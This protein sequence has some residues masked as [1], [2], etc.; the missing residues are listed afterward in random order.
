[1]VGE[2]YHMTTVGDFAYAD[3]GGEDLNGTTGQIIYTGDTYTP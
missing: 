1:M 2:S 3:L